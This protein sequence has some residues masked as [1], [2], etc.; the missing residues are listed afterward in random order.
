MTDK[1]NT[2]HPKSRWAAL[3][4]AVIL[5]A[6]VAMPGQAS[7]QLMPVVTETGKISLSVDGLGT[8]SASGTIDV[9]KPSATATV[10][11]AAFACASRGFSNFAIPDGLVTINGT[12]INWGTTV[13]SSISSFNHLADVTAQ[14]A[15]ALDPLA[16]PAGIT[17]FTI[18]EGN[19]INVE[20]C[21]LAVIFDDPLEPVDHTAI[22]LFGA[23]NIAG[24]TFNISLIDPINTSDPNLVLDFGLG[25]S[26]GFQSGGGLGSVDN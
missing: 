13:P 12:G 19:P 23:Q 10:R 3:L 20:G 26:F 16:V 9:L 15:A 5:A 25:I 18:A 17:S 7:A 14:M 1:D 8:N 2:F 22:L 11:N 6:G 24:D 4:G 21:A